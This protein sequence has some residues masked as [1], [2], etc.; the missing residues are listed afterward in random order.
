MSQR[1]IALDLKINR[2]TVVRK[3]WFLGLWANALLPRV[4][5]LFEKAKMIEFDDLETSEHTKCKP[6]SGIIA[7]ETRTR[8]ILGYELAKMPA[9]GRLAAISKRKY[10]PR[11]DE[12]RIKRKVLFQYLLTTIYQCNFPPS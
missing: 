2:K 7:V 6:L 11:K 10:G 4:N 9:K 5:K 3:F 12:R 1:R 8:R